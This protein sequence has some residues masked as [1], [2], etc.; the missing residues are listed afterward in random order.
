[1]DTVNPLITMLDKFLARTEFQLVVRQTVQKTGSSLSYAVWL[2]LI[3]YTPLSYKPTVCTPFGYKS[4]VNKNYDALT[5]SGLAY[6]EADQAWRTRVD[7]KTK[8]ARA[9]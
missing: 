2:W 3:V 1:M 9:K 8:V 7:A 5:L 4:T 6:L